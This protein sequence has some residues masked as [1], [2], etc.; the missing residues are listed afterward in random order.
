MEH[1]ITERDN[2][3]RDFFSLRLSPYKIYLRILNS[4]EEVLRTHIH[5]TKL[6]SMGK[7]ITV[8]NKLHF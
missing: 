3:Q 1:N 6:S 4:D 2:M 8:R 7:S 5:K